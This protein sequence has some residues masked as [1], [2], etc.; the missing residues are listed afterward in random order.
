[1]IISVANCL[2]FAF[3]EHDIV[4]RLCGDEFS[5]SAAEV[6]D[7]NVANAIIN[8]FIDNLKTIV[9]SELE[10]TAITANISAIIL[11]QGETADFTDN[12]KLIDKGVYESKKIKGSHVTFM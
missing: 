12:Y 2:K 10:E 3:R 8:R 7:K 6:H 4:F 5:A 1:M 9:I 11:P